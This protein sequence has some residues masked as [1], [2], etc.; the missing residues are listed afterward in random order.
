MKREKKIIIGIFLFVSTL[1]LYVI[2]GNKG[3]RK[4]EF[5]QPINGIVEDE[6]TAIKIAEI[7]GLPVFGKNL[8]DYKPFHAKL[9]ND[10][11]WYVYGL[12]KKSWFKVQMGGGP[13]FE[14]QKIDGRLLK[15]YI[16][17]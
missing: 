13:V 3:S 17:K 7:V 4:L 8:K 2:V 10:S 9:E 12:P 1:V 14:I 11:I 6:V 5:N 16:S 15:V